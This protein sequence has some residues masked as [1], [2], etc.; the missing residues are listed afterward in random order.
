M[1][2]EVD[3]KKD[4]G[5]VK[6][7]RVFALVVKEEGLRVLAAACPWI[8]YLEVM[9]KEQG[10]FNVLCSPKMA[11]APAG[12]RSEEVENEVKPGT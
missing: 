10:D 12:T 5:E 4:E 2:E 8:S 3:V 7:E 11:V 6:R 1:S 9:G